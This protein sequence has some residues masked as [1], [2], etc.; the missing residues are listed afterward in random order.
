MSLT[1]LVARMIIHWY[2]LTKEVVEFLSLDVFKSKNAC[3]VGVTGFGSGLT[4]SD[5]HTS[6][7]MAQS[8]R[9]KDAGITRASHVQTHWVK[10]I[11]VCCIVATNELRL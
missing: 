4:G 11:R 9:C 5:C 8:A 1:F 6:K 3:Q 10:P 7:T 2:K